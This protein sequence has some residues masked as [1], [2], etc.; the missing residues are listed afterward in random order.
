MTILASIS[1]IYLSS[2]LTAGGADFVCSESLA[3]NEDEKSGEVYFVSDWL[4]DVHWFGAYLRKGDDRYSIHPEPFVPGGYFVPGKPDKDG[5]SNFTFVV[6][7]GFVDESMSQIR[8]RARHAKNPTP[9]DA[10]AVAALGK[11]AHPRLILKP[12]DDVFA[13]IKQATATNE[14]LAAAVRHMREYADLTLA[15]KPDPYKLDGRR[16][17]SQPCTARTFSLAQMWKMTGDRRHP[18]A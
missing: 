6:K 7:P 13:R 5:R 2:A 3:V 11:K 4:A 18:D 8:F 17:W 15:V 10:A 14:L 12:N 9:P 16:L 1:T